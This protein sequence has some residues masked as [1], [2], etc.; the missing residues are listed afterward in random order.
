M[1]F[2]MLSANL[3]AGPIRF[4]RPQDG[5][6]FFRDRDLRGQ[7]LK[8]PDQIVMQV[9]RLRWLGR[10]AVHIDPGQACGAIPIDLY[11]RFFLSLPC[12]R[13]RQGSIRL[14]DMPARQQPP[15][16]TVMV[17]EQD[18]GTI[19][20]KHHRSAGHMPR[21]ELMARERSVRVPQK[22]ECQFPALPRKTI[23]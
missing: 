6:R 4:L 17:Y 2:L 7:G 20:M 23:G 11:Q 5:R 21:R 8:T 22:I 14:F 9:K 16:K 3:Q 12:R 18:P 13:R 19:G 10:N 1:L 15:V